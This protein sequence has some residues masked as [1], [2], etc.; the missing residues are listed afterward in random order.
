M[1]VVLLAQL[2]PLQLVAVSITGIVSTGTNNGNQISLNPETSSNINNFYINQIL[3]VG[4]Q[5]STITAYSGLDSYTATVNPAYSNTSNLTGSLYQIRGQKPIYIGNVSQFFNPTGLTIT[6][7]STF[8]TSNNIYSG[9]YLRATSG[10]DAGQ[11]ALINYSSSTGFINLQSG[12]LNSM[13]VGDGVEILEFT[14]DNSVPL[15]YSGTDVINQPVAYRMRLISLILPNLTLNCGY[16]GT[17]SNYPYLYVKFYLEGNNSAG[18]TLYSNNPYSKMTSFKSTIETADYTL[19]ENFI[20]IELG[21][22]SNNTIQ[23]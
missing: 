15:L 12:F 19:S 13:S 10:I 14:R 11:I 1:V 9:K 5:Y 21:R 7:N 18:Q 16:G 4:S 23:T 22:D 6:Q 8:N 17:I 3:Q 2:T 20:G